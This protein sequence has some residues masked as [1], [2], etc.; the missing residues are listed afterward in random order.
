MADAGAGVGGGGVGGGAGGR[1]VRRGA[2]LLR[3]GR[4]L[5]VGDA[6]GVAVASGDRSRGA[7]AALVRMADGEGAG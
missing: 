5:A 3:T 4:P 7:V 6:S 1:R 2:E